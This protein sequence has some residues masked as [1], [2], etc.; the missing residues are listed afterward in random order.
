MLARTCFG[1]I[2]NL[3]MRQYNGVAL[4]FSIRQRRLLDA[5]QLTRKEREVFGKPLR[6]RPGVRPLSKLHPGHPINTDG[7]LSE[8]Y[9]LR[10]LRRWE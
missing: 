4:P 10:D 9:Q 7:P 5:D 2:K 8:A 6:P 3:T 1:R